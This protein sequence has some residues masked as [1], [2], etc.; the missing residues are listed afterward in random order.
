MHTPS[1]PEDLDSP[2]RLWARAVTFALV[3]EARGDGRPEHAL[4]EHGLWCHSTGACGWWRLTLVE[5]G[6]AVFV[7]QDPDGSHTHMDGEQID[8]LAGG[9]DWL[10]WEQLRDDAEG[11][12]FGFVYWWEN[13]AWHRIPYPEQLPEDGLEGAAPWVGSEEEFRTLTAA[14]A[15]ADALTREQ[16]RDLHAAVTRFRERAE[17]RTVGEA[18][19][20]A[21]LAA[22]LPDGVPPKRLE[23]ATDLAV[24]AGLTGTSAP[25]RAV[26]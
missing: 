25:E 8:F 19:V 21:L 4:D 15:Q 5:G 3:E 10:P 2:A 20:A 6:R 1:L 9:P 18:D 26:G 7:G 16:R 22:A 13:S 23:A 24:R 14:L 17:E 11:N 12:L